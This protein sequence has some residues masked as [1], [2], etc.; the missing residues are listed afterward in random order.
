MSNS[1]TS[2][3]KLDG[4][5]S[6]FAIL[7]LRNL[8]VYPGI[9]VPI[10]VG[11]QQSLEALKSA[12][13]QAVPSGKPARVIAVLQSAHEID[14]TLPVKESDLYRVGTL[15]EIERIKG[16]ESDGVQLLIKGLERVTLEDFQMEKSSLPDVDFISAIAKRETE[17]K[18]DQAKD[19]AAMMELKESAMRLVHLLPS[20]SG[21]EQ[22]TKLLDGITDLD[23]LTYIAASN[24]EVSI[25]EKQALLEEP[26]RN[27]RAEKITS[28]MNRV[29]SELQVKGEIREK[30]NTKLGKTQRDAILR[31][32]M[33]AI[34]EELGDE[35]SDSE[36]AEDFRLKI[37]NSR[38]PDEV[39]KVA[40]DELKRL[41][42]L[43]NQ[44]PE[45]HIIRNYLDLLIALPWEAEATDAIDL[46]KARASLEADH[47]GLEKVKKRNHRAFGDD[48]ASRWRTRNDTAF[49]RTAWRR[50]NLARCIHR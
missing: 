48:E 6:R 1:E 24:L 20:S 26:D 30:L 32:Q 36:R 17:P 21:A 47:E 2:A 13:E 29:H 31:E 42:G 14:H 49:G 5:T 40:I 3:S 23:F 44:S 45:T 12:R 7:A 11:R 46:K 33:K 8:V 50:Q 35:A 10:R 34:R 4:A 22:L 27:V 28:I 37:E 39:R 41:E 15:C 43:S 25:D 9:S 16:S 19:Q 38:M 18:S